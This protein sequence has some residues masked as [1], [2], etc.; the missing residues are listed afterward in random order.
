MDTAMTAPPLD[1]DLNSIDT[2]IPLLED[3][4][5][6]LQIAKVEKTKSKAGGDMLKLDYI[7]T[8]PA[9]SR[10]G[11]QLGLGIH[12]FDQ[13]M[14]APAGKSDWN[15]V[16]R[17]IAAIT[18]GAALTGTVGEFL[19]GGYVGLQGRAIRVKIGYEPEGTDKNGKSFK[20]KNVISLYIKPA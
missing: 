9:K 15:M 1:Q 2:S 4:I 6:D 14:M 3:G 7:T 11:D 13:C 16:V 17:N 20:A 10:S 19:N 5:Y 18:Q 12:V 8:G